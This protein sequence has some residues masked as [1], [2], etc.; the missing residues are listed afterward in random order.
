M[1]DLGNDIVLAVNE[2]ATVALDEMNTA[3]TAVDEMANDILLDVNAI[4][5]L[6][7]NV[8]TGI[9]DGVNEAGEVIEN[10]ANEAEEAIVD[11]VNEAGEAIENVA[12]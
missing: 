10:A 11:G 1:L 9:I 3:F 4:P 5:D 2:E 6:A 12:I 7:Y 8:E